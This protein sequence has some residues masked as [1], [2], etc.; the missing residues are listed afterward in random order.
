MDDTIYSL[1]FE[2][3][4]CKQA[5][6]ICLLTPITEMQYLGGFIA[7][8]DWCLYQSEYSAHGEATLNLAIFLLRLCQR[9]PRCF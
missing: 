2:I 1:I 4:V 6:K 5:I 7:E 8:L 3:E 9:S